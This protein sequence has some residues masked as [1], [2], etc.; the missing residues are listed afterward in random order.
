M[1]RIRFAELDE[2][3]E[4]AAEDHALRVH[5]GLG[6][7]PGARAAAGPRGLHARRPRAARRRPAPSPRRG[8]A[9]RSRSTLPAR[10][11]QPGDARR[12]STRS[13]IGRQLRRGAGARPSPTR[14]SSFRSTAWAMEPAVR[15]GAASSSTS[16]WS[17]DE[18]PRGGAIRTILERISRSGEPASLAVL[19]RFGD[20]ALARHAL[21][22]PA[23][24]HAGRRLRRPGSRHVR[25]ARRA[26]RH[27]ARGGRRGLSGEGRTDEPAR[28]SAAFFPAARAVSPATWIPSSPPPSGAGCMPP[29]RRSGCSSSAPPPRSPRRPPASTPRTERGCSSPAATPN[30][31]RRSPPTSGSAARP[32]S[33]P[34][35]STRPITSAARSVVDAGVGGPRRAGRGT[36]RPRRAAG[37][38]ALPGER[39]GSARAHRRQLRLGGGAAHAAGQ[40]VRGGAARMHR[41][42]H[43]GGRRSRAA[44]QL[45]LRRRQGRARPASSRGCGTGC[46]RAGVAVVTLKP[47]FVDTPMTADIPRD[48]LFASARRRGPRRPPGDRAP[49]GR[50]LHS[51]VLASDHGRHSSLPEAVFK[52]LRL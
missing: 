15:A 28:A 49:P 27:R 26:R 42:H 18:P 41:G 36:A 8:P 43:L 1:E 23:R 34:R 3:F 16:A 29:D 31:W 35:C 9:P 20:G 2:F 11:A 45:R 48:P 37:S 22:P 47:G 33:R 12:S 13:T 14:R 46:I 4:L 40:P 50:R 38:G 7:L 39:R 5:R 21:V 17:R 19:K 30:G 25:P 24:A 32:R 51:L 10:T 6:G 52:R 44:E